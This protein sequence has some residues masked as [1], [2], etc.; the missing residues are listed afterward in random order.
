MVHIQHR[1]LQIFGIWL[2]GKE[3]KGGS[4][5]GGA[6]PPPKYGLEREGEGRR[7]KERITSNFTHIKP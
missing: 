3:K 1:M 7:G 2:T 4:R 6:G 5:K